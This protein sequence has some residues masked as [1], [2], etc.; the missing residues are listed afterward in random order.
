MRPLSL[1]LWKSVQKLISGTETRRVRGGHRSWVPQLESRALLAGTAVVTQSGGTLTITGVDDLTP[2]GIT[3]GLNNQVITIVGG[4]AG[5]VT[6]AGVGTTVT[7]AGFYSGVTAIK[8][9]LKLGNDQATLTNVQITGALTYLGGDGN[10]NLIMNGATGHTYGSIAV[11]NGD[12]NDDFNVT[13]T[14]DLTVTGALTINYGEGD[15]DVD[16]GD[17]AASDIVLGSFKYTSGDGEDNL[18]LRSGT[19]S[20]LGTTQVTTGNGHHTDLGRR[21][22]D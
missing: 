17:N 12:G 10:N 13:G 8:F 7:G 11:T 15:G 6:V 16:L 18:D 22:D 5:S 9:D 3:G 21:V 2:A 19:L 20:I 4:G 14:G 1:R